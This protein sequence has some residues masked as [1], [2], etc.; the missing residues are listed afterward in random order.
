[1]YP[2]LGIISGYDYRYSDYYVE[3]LRNIGGNNLETHF[4]GF[5]PQKTMFNQRPGWNR[6]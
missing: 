6:A 4:S 1:M 2:Q 3:V 5:N